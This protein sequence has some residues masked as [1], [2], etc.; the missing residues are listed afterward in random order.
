MVAPREALH[1]A[2]EDGDLLGSTSL[3]ELR[4]LLGPEADGTVDQS[5]GGR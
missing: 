3:Q 2:W 1:R 5:A 4:C